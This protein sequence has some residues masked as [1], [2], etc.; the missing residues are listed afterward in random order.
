MSQ[1]LLAYNHSMKAYFPLL[2]AFVPYEPQWPN[3]QWS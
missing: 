1:N 2:A 3:C